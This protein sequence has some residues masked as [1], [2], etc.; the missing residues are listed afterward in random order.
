MAKQPLSLGNWVRDQ[1]SEQ[2]QLVG[3]DA[4]KK[5]EENKNY[6]NSD[7]NQLFKNTSSAVDV[8]AYPL[9]QIGRYDHGL[10]S[11]EKLIK[12]NLSYGD[13]TQLLND[14]KCENHSLQLNCKN[15]YSSISDC[16]YTNRK[17]RQN[18]CNSL[19]HCFNLEHIPTKETQ[20]YREQQHQNLGSGCESLGLCDCIHF[21]EEK[22]ISER[23]KLP[24]F[25]RKDI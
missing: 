1:T 7:K 25:H 17:K 20:E 13:P 11:I 8:F 4:I 9:P 5:V 14:V 19:V 2:R 16:N 18:D 21:T 10:P 23:N 3:F 12:D 22:E 24:I 15:N 6:S